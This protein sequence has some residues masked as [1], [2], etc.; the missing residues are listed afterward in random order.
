MNDKT[1]ASPLET[2]Y[3]DCV[4]T[5]AEHTL[6][7]M[8]DPDFGDLYAELLLCQYHP[9]YKRLWYAFKYVLGFS[10]SHDGAGHFSC[11]ALNT[12]HCEK[13]ISLLQRAKTKQEEIAKKESKC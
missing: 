5:M 13:L 6:R 8:Y 11:W 12:E 3:F 4:C 7:F 2:H 1:V 9:W 10:N